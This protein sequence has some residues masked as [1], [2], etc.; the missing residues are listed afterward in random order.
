MA[1]EPIDQFLDVQE[2]AKILKMSARFIY[3]TL[4]SGKGP[5]Y[6]RF[7]G[8]RGRYRIRYSDLMRW[9]S[10]P[11]AKNH[12][13]HQM[14]C[15]TIVFGPSATAWTLMFKTKEAAEAALDS[16]GL[17][18]RDAGG[19]LA[20]RASRLDPSVEG[21]SWLAGDHVTV[22]DDFGQTIALNKEVVHGTMLEDM[23]LSKLAHIERGLHIA[24][25]NAEGQK[26]ARSDPTLQEYARAPGIISPM[27]MGNGRMSYTWR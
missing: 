7:S 9:A 11:N 4:R 23:S 1:G 24:R 13:W 12:G 17:S 10:K 27:G 5:R 21:Q 18:L 22:V 20:N 6:Q 8:P 25:T 16:A 26:I 15:L 14:H 19:R 3:D 2:C